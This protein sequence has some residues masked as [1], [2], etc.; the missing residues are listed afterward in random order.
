MLLQDCPVYFTHLFLITLAVNNNNNTVIKSSVRT[1]SFICV[2]QYCMLN[3]IIDSLIL[4]LSSKDMKVQYTSRIIANYVK[5][6]ETHQYPIPSD[7]DIRD[8]I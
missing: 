2:R 5:I 3:R 4:I 6:S 8:F 7:A 1:S